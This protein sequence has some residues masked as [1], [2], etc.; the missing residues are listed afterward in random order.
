MDYGRGYVCRLQEERLRVWG[1]KGVQYEG[2]GVLRVQYEG[3]G[4]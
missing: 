3:V 1:V 2:V 4:C